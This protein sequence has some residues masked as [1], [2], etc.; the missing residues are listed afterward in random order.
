MNELPA[1]PAPQ[2]VEKVKRLLKR[3]K[4]AK[5]PDREAAEQELADMGIE[6]AL[7]VGRTLEPR[8]AANRTFQKRARI[9]TPVV[10]AA[11][12]V[13]IALAALTCLLYPPIPVVRL[14]LAIPNV[15]AGAFV[16][17]QM[18][19]PGA[20]NFRSAAEEARALLRVPD[21]RLLSYLMHVPVRDR[22][23]RDEI[24][25]TASALLATLEADD[26][27]VLTSGLRRE[28]VEM[29][30]QVDKPFYRGQVTPELEDYL[31][32]VLEAYRRVGDFT[33]RPVVERLANSAHN[34]R[35]QRAAREC[36]PFLPDRDDNNPDTLLRASS[37]DTSDL[38]RASAPQ[39]E[40]APEQLLRATNRTD[41]RE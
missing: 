17:W 20:R 36:L 40:S 38:L 21:K 28:I 14:I 24:L 27:Y 2:T 26:A 35:I 12:L 39:P 13:M 29:L 6:G 16:M 19:G 22:A 3:I 25:R 32:A 30:A 7:A 18:S 4:R 5:G 10:L 1:E 23:I 31:V 11:P 9:V 37:H 34:F 15:V 41:R 8:I 33:A